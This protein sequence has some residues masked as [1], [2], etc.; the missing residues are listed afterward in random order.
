MPKMIQLRHVPD[1]LHR[2][3][4]ARAALEGVSLSDYLLREIQRLA[5]R[6]TVRELKLRLAQ[7]SRVSPRVPPVRAVRSERDRA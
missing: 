1:D 6:P 4:K 3:L 2:V 7:R 5:E